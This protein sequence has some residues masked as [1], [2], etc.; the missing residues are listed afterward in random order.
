MLIGPAHSCYGPL[1]GPRRDVFIIKREL[2]HVLG[3]ASSWKL[4][5]AHLCPVLIY[6]SHMASSRNSETL[7]VHGIGMGK[8]VI[9]FFS[10]IIN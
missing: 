10:F 8:G 6:F 2:A 1:C 4:F 7:H 5:R 9:F 3:S